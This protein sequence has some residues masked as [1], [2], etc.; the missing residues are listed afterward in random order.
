[1]TGVA[2]IWG[3][4]GSGA[5]G[6]GA[7]GLPG[8]AA[9]APAGLVSEVSG[10]A[11]LVTSLE[12]DGRSGWKTTEFWASITTWLLPILTLIWH[13]DLTSLAVPLAVVAAAGAQ[14]V[15]T[16]SRAITKKGHAAA[17]A[18]MAAANPA[19]LAAVPPP[20]V[21]PPPPAAAPAPVPPAGPAPVPPAAPAPVPAAAP[22]PEPAEAAAPVL[23]DPPTAAPT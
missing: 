21:L 5:A 18:S 10:L 1:M 15:Y 8:V 11:Q 23:A 16:I 17:I 6:S 9:A 7:I 13:R 2:R 20:A 14:A 12:H 22:A 4:A 19:L 3:A